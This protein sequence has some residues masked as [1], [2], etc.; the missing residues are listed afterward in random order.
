[1]SKPA[2]SKPSPLL[3]WG[4]LLLVLGLIGTAVWYVAKPSD[5]VAGTPAGQMTGLGSTDTIWGM[6]NPDAT[7]RIVEFGD[8]QCGACAYYHPI[9]KQFME[10]FG[11][12][13]YFE[14]RHFPLPSHGFARTAARA[15]EAAGRQ[16]KFWEMHDLIMTGQAQWVNGI[17]TNVFLQ[18]ARSIGINDI[19]FQQD[20]R[21]PDIQAKIERDFQAGIQLNIQSVPSFFF[22]GEY[23]RTPP[24]VDGFRELIRQRLA[25]DGN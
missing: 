3:T 25:S 4:G 23:V 11:D 22:N 18:Y 6:G 21:N 16:G 24:N 8:Y 14:Y 1:M 17:P 12:R 9:V 15:A 20:L 7:L 13:V 10:E 19:Q 2:S 5:S